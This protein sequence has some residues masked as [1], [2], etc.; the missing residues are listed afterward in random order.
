[1]R[2]IFA[3][4]PTLCEGRT[5]YIKFSVRDPKTG[6]L[7]RQRIYDGFATAKSIEEKRANADKL[8]KKYTDLLRNGWTPW[9]DG[10]YI[11]DDQVMYKNESD[12]F[13]CTKLGNNNVRKL[14]SEFLSFK[15]LSLKN[16]TYQSYQSK[17]RLFCLWCEKHRLADVNISAITNDN[18]I[19]FFQ[20]HLIIEKNLDKITV[21]IYQVKIRAMFDFACKKKY[22][23]LNPV[24][25]IPQ[26]KKKVDI[27]PRPI[28]KHDLNRLL[29]A[30]KSKDP[31][32]YLACL[33]QY[34]CAIRPGTE[35]RLLKLKHI[36]LSN[37]RITINQMDAKS[38]RQDVI[39]IPVPLLTQMRDIYCL[40]NFDQELYLFGRNGYPGEDHLGQNTLRNRFNVFRNK[41]GLS[42]E[43]KF[44]SLKHTG[45]SELLESG[46]TFKDLMD[47]LRHSDIQS[48]Y[49]YIR[50]HKGMSSDN[51]KNHFPTP[52]DI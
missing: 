36:D 45:A 7:V 8:I 40:Q 23:T 50:K 52:F 35:L 13:G 25:D 1:M 17:M 20:D 14:A 38:N 11:Y 43:Y 18:I 6:K 44:Y 48:T 34:F 16:K 4:L 22:I 19:S 51:I 24:Y 3:T 31:Q 29:G 37:G 21:K 28:N 41:L 39:Q 15:K 26:A 46:I 9:T 27:A 47:H 32:L 12:V 42:K 10:E 49:H 33:M 2:K 5:W 30:I